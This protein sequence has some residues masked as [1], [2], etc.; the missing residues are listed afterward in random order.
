MYPNLQNLWEEVRELT[1]GSTPEIDRLHTPPTPLH[2]L[3][4]YLSQN[5]PFILSASTLPWPA[6]TLWSSTSYLLRTLSS[7]TVS[8]HRTP[9]GH[10]DALTPHPSTPNSFCFASADVTR[11]S[12]ADAVD[13]VTGSCK[14]SCVAYLQQQND[15]F[16]EEYGALSG[17]CDSDVPW[18]TEAIGG[19]PEA[20]NLWIGNELSETWFHK[21]HYE[22]LY[23]V[24]TGEKHFVL[25]PPTD[26]HRMYVREYPAAHYNYNE[27]TGEFKLQLENPPRHVPWCS[28][29]P[30][31][32]PE[33]QDK[34][35]SEFPL[36][37]NGPKP[38][39][40]TVKAGEILYLPSMWF[41]HVRQTPDSRG[42][43]IAVNYWY[44]MQFDIKYAYF[45]FLQSLP[46]PQEPT[47]HNLLTNENASDGE[48]KQRE[49]PVFS[50]V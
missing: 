38:F 10:A 25:L 48:D 32:S 13:A 28:V 1:L 42:L 16:R 7:S 35:M 15:C 27:E 22:N 37:F 9:T 26:V 20:V 21:D 34:E 43:T 6:A 3:R 18:A 31:P 45:N 29:N 4:H 5:K 8:L 46:A 14:E 36:Y 11:T 19:G 12:F 23:A 44:D 49:E 33:N 17:D 40:V 47:S 24:V 41:H 30:Y 50:C 39:E 2:F